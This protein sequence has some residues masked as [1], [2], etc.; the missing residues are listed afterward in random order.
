MRN[1]HSAR[2][3]RVV[4]EVALCNIWRLFTNDLYRVFVG[5]DGAIC[6][7]APEHSA[8]LVLSFSVEGRIERKRVESHVIYDADAEVILRLWCIQL[9]KHRL[10]HCGRKF[11]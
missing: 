10:N 3:L 2:F 11:F 5:A 4:N 8:N 6:T 1:S 7:Q 9:I